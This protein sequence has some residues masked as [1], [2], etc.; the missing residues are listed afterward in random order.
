MT[1]SFFYS[2]S[3]LRWYQESSKFIVPS[4][5]LCRIA[6]CC[7]WNLQ[8]LSTCRDYHEHWNYFHPQIFSTIFPRIL[9]LIVDCWRTFRSKQRL[10]YWHIYTL[11]ILW[12]KICADFYNCYQV[13]KKTALRGILSRVHRSCVNCWTKK[14]CWLWTHWLDFLWVIFPSYL[15]C[16]TLFFINFSVCNT[17][18]SEMTFWNWNLLAPLKIS[19]KNH[20]TARIKVWNWKK[21][22]NSS[23][24]KNG[25]NWK[26]YKLGLKFC[27]T[28]AP[29][30]E[31]N[32]WANRVLDEDTI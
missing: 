29:F 24:P 12:P 20:Q 3:R 2:C 32:T 21:N 11:L 4:T 9:P 30:L 13:S 1:R 10:A 19:N 28:P 18:L 14:T 7:V 8:T 25:Q 16:Y 27:T 17:I 6:G 22:Q 15:C 5:F 23:K 26:F 31:A